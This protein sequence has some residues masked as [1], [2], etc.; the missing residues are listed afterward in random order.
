M[1]GECVCTFCMHWWKCDCPYGTCYDDHRA[2]IRPR[3]KETGI[4]RTGWSNCERPGEQDHW[5]RGGIFY[6]SEDCEKF[7]QYEGQTIVQ[8]HRANYSEFQDGSR[9]CAMFD[10]NGTCSRCLSELSKKNGGIQ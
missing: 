4:H 7:E 9:R 8:C 5:C 1:C 10:E 2:E 3:E 6:P